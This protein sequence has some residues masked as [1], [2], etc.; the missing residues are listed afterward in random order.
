VDILIGYLKE[1][2]GLLLLVVAFLIYLFSLGRAEAKQIL[3]SLM[4]RAEKEVEGYIFRTGDEKF[5]FVVSRGY[6]LLPRYVKLIITYS[7]FEDM[8]Q[9][10]YNKAKEYL[11]SLDDG[12]KPK[13]EELQERKETDPG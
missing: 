10:L 7:M 8:A 11:Y 9:A 4:L 13:A 3:L 12:L 2:W 1:Y 5:S 6:E